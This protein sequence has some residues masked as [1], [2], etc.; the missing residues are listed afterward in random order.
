MAVNPDEFEEKLL[1]QTKCLDAWKISLIL[2]AGDIYRP[3]TKMRKGN[4]FTSVCQDNLSNL[5]TGG[6]RCTPTL[7][8]PPKADT[9]KADTTLG[10]H[11]LGK[12]PTGQIP[13]WKTPLRDN[14]CSRRYKS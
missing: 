11:P 10:R 4:V 1:E 8:R 13:P 14:Y 12:D 6:T 9:P 7:G 3:Q 5:S 2:T